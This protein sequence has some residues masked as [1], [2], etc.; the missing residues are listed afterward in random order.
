MIWNCSK[1]TTQEKESEDQSNTASN[2]HQ[3]LLDKLAALEKEGN[4]M[5]QS[6]EQRLKEVENNQEKLKEM[7]QYVKLLEEDN[8]MLKREVTDTAAAKMELEERYAASREANSVLLAELRQQKSF[9]ATLEAEIARISWA[10]DQSEEVLRRKEMEMENAQETITKL[11]LEVKWMDEE[12]T[13]TEKIREIQA[14]NPTDETE[15]CVGHSVIFKTYLNN[16]HYCRVF[17]YYGDN[18]FVSYS[19]LRQKIQQLHQIGTDRFDLTYIDRDGDTILLDGYHSYRDAVER[20][21]RWEKDG[22]K[23]ILRIYVRITSEDRNSPHQHQQ[24]LHQQQHKRQRLKEEN[25]C[26]NEKRNLSHGIG[27][28]G[29]ITKDYHSTQF[30]GDANLVYPEP[31]PDVEMHSATASILESTTTNT[32]SSDNNYQTSIPDMQPCFDLFCSRDIEEN[33]WSFADASPLCRPEEIES[34]SIISTA[35][36]FF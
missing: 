33:N 29:S 27:F 10:Q 35:A 1:T 9:V 17:G 2:H 14:Q 4:N 13:E 18:F 12:R 3:Q 34:L 8:E 15:F 21:D 7:E 6:T 22:Y 36:R 23:C 31:I 24:Q 26:E 11:Q 20:G 25:Q 30:I 16:G 19:D 32:A 5:I 28:P